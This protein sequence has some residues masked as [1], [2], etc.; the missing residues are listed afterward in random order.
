MGT[1]ALRLDLRWILGEAE[2]GSLYPTKAKESCMV[3]K[4]RELALQY[5]RPTQ[6]GDSH[7]CGEGR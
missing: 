4:L 7:H 1:L 5:P 6:G 2:V 3:R